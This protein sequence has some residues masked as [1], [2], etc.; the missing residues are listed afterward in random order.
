VTVACTSTV[1]FTIGGTLTGLSSG[2][3]V[4][5]ADNGS[6]DTLTLTADGSFTFAKSVASGAAYAVTV[7]TQP[8]GEICAVNNGSGTATAN[9]TNVSVSCSTGSGFTIGGT[10]YDLSTNA[11]S[12]GIVLQNNGGDNLTLATNGSFT[13][14]TPVTGA[15]KVTISTQPSG[16]AQSCT[17]TNGSGTASANVTNVQ[18]V[19]ISE[20]SWINGANVVAVGGIYPNNT[21]LGPGSRFGAYTWT[22]SAGKFWLYGG[23]GYDVNGP[24]VSSTQF[25]GAESGLGDLLNY[26]GSWHFKFG[27]AQNGQCF[28]YP[29]SVGQPGTPNGRSNGVSWIDSAGNLWMF[30]GYVSYMSDITQCPNALVADAFNDVWEFTGGQWIWQGPLASS[31]PK[32]NG[33]YGTKG[34]PGGTPGARYYSTGYSDAS[35]NFWMFG[36]YGY[37]ASSGNIGFLN[38]LWKFDGTQ[39]TW[40]SGSST[41]NQ[42][43]VY[44]G[45]LV[46][47]SRYGASSWVDS[48]GNF[49][50]F[51][52]DGYDSAGGV[53]D[54]NDLWE[55][56]PSTSKWTFIGGSKTAN[57]SSGTY[58][59]Q[60]VPASA[61]AP[62]SRVWSTTWV[63]ANGD[64]WL[65]GGQYSPRAEFLNDLW[66]YSGGQWTWMGPSVGS[67][68]SEPQFENILGVYPAST[69]LPPS[70]SNAPGSRLSGAAWTDLN[71]N[72]WLF[73]GYGLGSLP[74]GS[75]TNVHTGF[76]TLQD[77][78]EFQP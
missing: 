1:T 57:A 43:G 14:A 22:D 54:M 23:F 36:G 4:V 39:W 47:G 67:S 48:S 13:F 42:K 50:L 16:P 58:G 69:G 10:L 74:V 34:S 21:P 56:T 19:C 7:T 2:A 28:A 24:I 3:N 33:S 49:W 59:V 11:S 53:G 46:P 73:G 60:G 76:D 45:T 68:V 31:N 71:G 78:W 8:T 25:R 15:Y 18:V 72:L 27:Q 5:L 35:G 55:F 62:G 12:T 38:D 77:L 9:V 66:K 70:P 75:A 32:Q 40:I 29:T 37:D 61:N 52:G 26:D 63:D 65:M 17:V 20:W 30:G 41:A 44:T 64:V 51:G 6:F